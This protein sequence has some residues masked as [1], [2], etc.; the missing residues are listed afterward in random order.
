MLTV[1]SEVG[2][3]HS[4]SADVPAFFILSSSSFGVSLNRRQV[5]SQPA[6]RMTT[7]GLNTSL[8]VAHSQQCSCQ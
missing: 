2:S 4:Q 1:L 3:R 8:S 6:P 7:P 5:H